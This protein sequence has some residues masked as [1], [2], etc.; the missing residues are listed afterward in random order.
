MPIPELADSL[1]Q[2]IYEHPACRVYL[3]DSLTDFHQTAG[4]ELGGTLSPQ[5]YCNQLTL[6]AAPEVDSA[7]LEF[8]FATQIPIGED[9]YVLTIL[10][11]ND[12]L[13]KAVRIEIDDTTGLTLAEQLTNKIVWFGTIMNVSTEGAG[14]GR[15]QVQALGVLNL[16]DHRPINSAVSLNAAGDDKIETGLGRPFNTDDRD[17]FGPI[18]NR[19]ATKLPGDTHYLFANEDRGR[20]KWTAQ[21]AVEYLLARH[22]PLNSDDQPQPEWMLDPETTESQPADWYDVQLATEGRTL[23]ELLDALLPRKRAMSYYVWYDSQ[24]QK[25]VLKMFTFLAEDLE[26]STEPVGFTPRLIPANP[27]QYTVDPSTNVWFGADLKITESSEAQY[28]VIEARGEQATT[29]CTLSLDPDYDEFVPDWSTADEAAYKAA[30]STTDEKL[31]TQY[32]TE[33]R[34]QHVYSRFRLSDDFDGR[35]SGGLEEYWLDPLLDEQ[36]TPQPIYNATT[37][38]SGHPLRIRGL[39][40]LHRLPFKERLDYSG[41]A[42]EGLALKAQIDAAVTAGDGDSEQLPPICWYDRP[43]DNKKFLLDR[44]STATKDEAAAADKLAYSFHVDLPRHEPSIQLRV[45]SGR[46]TLFAKT[47]FTTP[48]PAGVYATDW[49]PVAKNGIDYSRCYTTVCIQFERRLLITKTI[50]ANVTTRPKRV[51]V[52]DVPD[53]RLDYVLPET[54]VGVESGAIAKTTNGGYVR[55]DRERVRS[56]VNATAEWFGRVK[57]AVE[58][59]YKQPRKLLAIGDLITSVEGESLQQDIN[60]PVTSISYSLGNGNQSGETKIATGFAEV[61]FT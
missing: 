53:A 32:R 31:N 34:V 50:T 49:D 60:T 28:D 57:R 58:F 8:T 19:A 33:D 37:N 51:L 17:Q 18:G 46:Q 4:V 2:I 40:L 42:L 44:L 30:A 11:P 55:D 16:A 48:A 59:S 25:I 43:S 41:T 24:R 5:L 21:T 6:R 38:P 35:V 10:T 22:V 36:G 7:E 27:N 14:I 39:K 56:I 9:A 1:D 26:V 13:G 15:L 61:D 47:D 20:E 52:I 3:A 29:T 12:L 45:S 23:K 54:V